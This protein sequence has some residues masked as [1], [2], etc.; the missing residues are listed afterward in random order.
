VALILGSG[1]MI[2]NRS[3]LAKSG[4]LTSSP[5]DN[6]FL[7]TIFGVG[8]TGFCAQLFRFLDAPNIIAYGTYFLHLVLVFALLIYSPYSKFAHFVY[9]TVALIHNRYAELAAAQA[10]PAAEAEVKEAQAA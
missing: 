10:A 4:D 8:V 3:K 6:F 2:W 1:L 9:R 5:Y 7:W